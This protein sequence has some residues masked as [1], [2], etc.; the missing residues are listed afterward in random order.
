VATTLVDAV[1]KLA[2][3]RGVPALH[4]EASDCAVPLFSRLGYEPQRRSS[5]SLGDEWLANTS[6]TKTLGASPAPLH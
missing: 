6:M 2:Q 5:V 3:A 4:V 1:E